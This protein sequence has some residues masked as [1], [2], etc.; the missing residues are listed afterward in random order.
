MNERFPSVSTEDLRVAAIEQA[1]AN[2]LADG[3]SV[4]RIQLPEADTVYPFFEMDLRGT[5]WRI[6]SKRYDLGYYEVRLSGDLQQLVF[7]HSTEIHILP[8]IFE[9]ATLIRLNAVGP[10][11]LSVLLRRLMATKK[12]N[13]VH[14]T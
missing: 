8:P 10:S 4:S 6:E 2:A 12:P 14:P 1:I 3:W 7:V 5:I 9:E 11:G 13:L